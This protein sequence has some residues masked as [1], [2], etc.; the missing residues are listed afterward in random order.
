MIEHGPSPHLLS[1]DAAKSV[2]LLIFDLD[3]TLADT[4]DDI[5]ASVNHMLQ[6]LGKNGIN[7][8]LVQRYVGD[9]IEKLVERAY[10]NG[11]GHAEAVRLYKQH[12]HT[13]FLTHSV[14]YAGVK[15][16][17]RY[18]S[19]MSMGVITNKSKEFSLPLLDHLGIRSYFCAI[20]GADEGLR[21]KPAPDAILKIM[22]ECGADKERTVIVGDGTTDILAGKAAGIATCAV[23]Y[24]FR[25]EEE[26]RAAGPD[27]VIQHFS[28]LKKLF[29]PVER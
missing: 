19:S 26:L 12:H 15:E 24:G 28:D 16:T 23:T 27:Y 2:E 3:G 22:A 20:I 14:L 4:L 21:L 1:P 8:D 18:F 29:A 7:R 10:G 25:T 5:T 6:A 9:G 17:L 11:A 13:N